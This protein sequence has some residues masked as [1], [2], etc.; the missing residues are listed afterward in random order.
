M[1]MSFAP[2]DTATSG[3]EPRQGFVLGPDD[4]QPYWWLGSLT[5]TKVT[6]EA[7]RGAMDIVDHRVP[8]GY[9]P[10]LHI[11]DDQDEVFYV[12]DGEFAVRCADQHWQAGPGSLVFL[13]RQI[14]HGFTV[15]DGGPGRTLLINAPAGFADVIAEL[16]VPASELVLPGP[17]VPMPDPGRVAAVS[18]AHGIHGV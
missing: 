14:A 11:H 1:H 8:A 10:P 12:I 16:G 4:G 13:P 15:S 6:R 18:Q 7:S 5:L 9:A 17:E 2:A 3:R